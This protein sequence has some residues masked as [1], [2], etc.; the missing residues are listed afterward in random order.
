MVHL[1][2]ADHYS[3]FD[4]MHILRPLCPPPPPLRSAR[5]TLQDQVQ[6]KRDELQSFLLFHLSRIQPEGRPPSLTHAAAAFRLLRLCGAAPSPGLL[7]LARIALEPKGVRLFNPFLSD[8]AV[9]V[10]HGGVSVWLQLCV[11]EDRLERLG[12][13]AQLGNE[14]KP[15]LIKVGSTW[16]YGR[17]IETFL[18][19][20]NRS[21]KV[22][23]GRGRIWQYRCK[24]S[25]CSGS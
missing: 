11:L 2:G 23:S 12:A 18:S 4:Q 13:L 21:S 25:G 1:H 17:C 8:D 22:S 24:P 14:F 7:D 19:T 9:A 10:L 3:N 15:T 6:C 20:G 16:P 5:F